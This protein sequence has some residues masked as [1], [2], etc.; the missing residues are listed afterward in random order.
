MKYIYLLLIL[1]F[2]T[3][4]TATDRIVLGFSYNYPP[5]GAE[6][7]N[8]NLPD[9]CFSTVDQEGNIITPGQGWRPHLAQQDEIVQAT[10]T[11]RIFLNRLWGIDPSH[12]DVQFGAR[13]DCLRRT[14]LRPLASKTSFVR[15]WSRFIKR[16]NL[17]EV[18]AYIGTPALDPSYPKN[19]SSDTQLNYIY[20]AIDPIL[21]TN[22]MSIGFDAATSGPTTAIDYAVTNLS[23]ALG[24]KVYIEA[25]DLGLNAPIMHDRLAGVFEATQYLNNVAP[26]ADPNDVAFDAMASRLVLL[27]NDVIIPGV[28]TPEQMVE[29]IDEYLA[30]RTKGGKKLDIM[31]FTWAAKQLVAKGLWKWND[32]VGDMNGDAE[33]NEE[34]VPLLELAVTDKSVYENRYPDIDPNVVGDINGNG[35]LDLED[36]P[37]LDG[38]L[39][40]EQR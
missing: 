37:A 3:T 4:A 16:N 12:P 31:I 27:H 17:K 15:D 28:T 29:I 8:M 33:I 36:I 13:N 9:A 21:S 18:I 24:M 35:A 7:R 40:Q 10:G 23:I 1:L 20:T 11:S 19:E 39:K 25:R 5:A 2:A 14:N 6:R 32:M 34:D 22:K 26:T 30:R 38:V